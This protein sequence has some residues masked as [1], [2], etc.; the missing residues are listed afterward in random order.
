MNDNVLVLTRPKRHEE[1]G[2]QRAVHRY[3]SWCL[4]EGCV[5]YAVPNGGWRHPG[6]AARMASQG[7]RPG[8]PDI[9]LICDAHPLFIELKTATGTLSSIQR[10]MH[11]KLADCGADVFVCRSVEHVQAVLLEAG[12]RLRGKLG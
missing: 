11:Q 6:E 12:V 8:V 7:V 1:D 10:Q 3:L 4:P 5:H 2:L 9:A